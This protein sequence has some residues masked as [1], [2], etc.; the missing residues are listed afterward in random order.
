MLTFVLMLFEETRTKSTIDVAV[1]EALP[2]WRYVSQNVLQG[3]LILDFLLCCC[4]STSFLLL[5]CSKKNQ[6]TLC[7]YRRECV[8]NT[9]CN[10]HAISDNT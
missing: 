9:I 4:Y 2:R 6:R 1:M 3:F 7:S 8:H 5:F 10:V